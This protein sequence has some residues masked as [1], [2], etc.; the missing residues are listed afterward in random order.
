MARKRDAVGRERDATPVGPAQ[1]L[2]IGLHDHVLFRLRA[3]MTVENAP[4]LAGLQI[5]DD[6]SAFG[7]GIG[8]IGVPPIRREPHIVEVA[9]LG[10][11]RLVEADHLCH[12]VRL[13]VDPDE[14][15]AARHD[16]CRCRRGRVDDPE[17]ALNVGDDALDADEVIAG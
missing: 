8:Q 3:W 9:A 15:G 1:L 14:L 17:I 16:G 10:C 7:P 4:G 12:L 13:Q 2:P 6:E 5:H 11:D